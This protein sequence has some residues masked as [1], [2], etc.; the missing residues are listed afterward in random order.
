[1]DTQKR[2]D[3]L[4][5]IGVVMAVLLVVGAYFFV[6]AQAQKQ[7][8]ADLQQ[9]VDRHTA[10]SKAEGRPIDPR[11]YPSF[12]PAPTQAE[13]QT[14]YTAAGINLNY[15]ASWQIKESDGVITT[16]SQ[17]ALLDGGVVPAD[18]G[19]MTVRSAAMSWLA[20]VEQLT[21]AYTTETKKFTVNDRQVFEVTNKDNGSGTSWIESYVLPKESTG[22]YIIITVYPAQSQAALSAYRAL[23]QTIKVS[24]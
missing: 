23:L 24:E 7:Q 6:Q 8:I 1:M 5:F 19:K 15:P 10:E 18:Q 12:S 14:S 9:K 2:Q 20:N 22:K 4:P 21:T 11:D 3:A 16:A 13:K 17:T